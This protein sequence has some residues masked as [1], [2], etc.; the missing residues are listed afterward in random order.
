MYDF[1][2]C[3]CVCARAH[4]HQLDLCIVRVGAYA[5]LLFFQVH[6]FY[7][8]LNVNYGQKKNDKRKKEK[9]NY[10]PLALP[11]QNG[12]RILGST[13]DSIPLIQ[14]VGSA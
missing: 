1:I 12:T 11:F 6:P 10:T 14:I 8:E 3:V 5:A 2:V 9:R 7:R 13:N 4:V